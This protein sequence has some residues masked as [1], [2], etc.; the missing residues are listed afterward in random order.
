MNDCEEYIYSIVRKAVLDAYPSA[1]VAGEYLQT[2]AKFPH[3]SLWVHDS[4]PKYGA[5][6]NSTTEDVTTLAFTVNVYS[7]LR[8]GKKS[9]VKAI[10]QLIDAEMYKLN[11]RRTSYLPVPN[12]LDTTIYR[13]TATY[14]VD[15]D[16]VNLYR[17]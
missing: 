2:P 5:Q 11:C 17:S 8:T 15:F 6:T 10:M 4:T 16:G 12:M 7:N 13:L 1:S 3:V 14:C 9:Q